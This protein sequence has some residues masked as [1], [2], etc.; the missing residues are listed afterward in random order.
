MS[1]PPADPDKTRHSQDDA[2]PVPWSARDARPVLNP[3]IAPSDDAATVLSRNLPMAARPEEGFAA[4][5]RGRRLGHYEL[6]EPIGVGGMAA[7]IRARDVHLDRLVALKILPPEMATD[8]E[9]VKRFEQEA[10]AAARLDHENIARVYDCGAEQGLSFIVFEFVEGENIRAILQRRGRIPVGE[11]VCYILQLAA[12]LAHAA[13]RG[14]VHRDIKPSNIIVGPEGRAKLVDMGLARNLGQSDLALTQP[15]VT[16][17]TF[18]YISPEQAL[19]PRQADCRS[20]I[21]SLGCTFYH[22]LT[23]Q[24]PVPEGTAARKLHHHQQVAPIDPRQLNP[25]VPDEIASI[26]ARMM[27]KNPDDRYQR[28]EELAQ[29]L[30]YLARKLGSP[31]LANRLLFVDTPPPRPARLRPILL[32]AAAAGILGVFV[33]WHAMTRPPGTFPTGRS[34]AYAGDSRGDN[35]DASGRDDQAPASLVRAS[36]EAASGR[37]LADLMSKKDP[38]V[39]VY[40]TQDLDLTRE[41]AE[42]GRVPGLIYAGHDADGRDRELTIQPKGRQPVT[43]RLKYNRDVAGEGVWSAFTIR[44]GRVTL[45]NL[46]FEVAA[47]RADDL[48]MA[49]LRLQENGLLTLEE[50]QFTQVNRT[51]ASG[52]SALDQGYVADVLVE[53]TRGSSVRPTLKL[54]GCYFAGGQ[55]AVA[56]A[57]SGEVNAWNCAFGP[58]AEL[59]HFGDRTGETDLQLFHCSALLSG[60]SA[61]YLEDSVAC[62]LAVSHCLFSQPEAPEAAGGAALIRQASL[63]ANVQYAGSKNRYHHLRAFWQN[64]GADGPVTDAANLDEF[65]RRAG[66]DNGSEELTASPWKESAPL[67]LLKKGEARPAFQLNAQEPALR[68]TIGGKE[69]LVGV[70]RCVWGTAYD[71]KLP[72]LPPTET[73]AG[74]IVD[75]TSD[76]AAAKNGP[77][78]VYQRLAGAVAD[79]HRGDTIYI[80]CNGPLPVQPLHLEDPDIDLTI[81][82]YKDYHPVLTLAMSSEP[83]A[84]LFRLNDGNL[85]LQELEFLLKPAKSG[86]LSQSV[87]S[88]AGTGHCSFQRCAMTLDATGSETSWPLAVTVLLDPSQVM[89]MDTSTPAAPDKVPKVD[90]D[91]CF[92]RGK[93]ELVAVRASRPLALKAAN[94]VIALA[95]SLLSV[96]G[97]STREPVDSG[98]NVKLDKVTAYLTDHLVLLR[99]SK[100]MKDMVRVDVQ[101]DNCLIASATR[102]GVVHFDGPGTNEQTVKD[103][104]SWA[105]QHNAYSN[106]QTMIDQPPMSDQKWSQSLEKEPRWLPK[107]QFSMPPADV[108]RSGPNDFKVPTSQA[109]LQSYGADVNDLPRP[110]T[111]SRG[112]AAQQSAPSPPVSPR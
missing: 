94:S 34:L 110:L 105:G 11:A 66:S 92:V 76:P 43:I 10:R 36:Y 102:K 109:D 60:G 33:L 85:K 75:P 71:P 40:L 99:T 22:M 44:G 17:G 73:V 78:R 16:L 107:A 6:I 95:G 80:R 112:A 88:V 8:A 42:S 21:Y 27:A 53:G 57:G 54:S 48:K 89:K 96:D 39:S 25:E 24:P 90:F 67:A 86:Y 20:D 35:G 23:G 70:Q 32:A 12:G 52:P 19:D 83:D 97:N 64:T 82:A 46:R 18:D 47:G 68:Q 9:I 98:I 77:A 38:V 62:R 4:T 15:G 59:F 87:V 103:R 51:A 14:V 31:E 41:Q 3:D 28:A 81:R 91:G 37:E 49:A 2:T 106:F 93:G 26:L 29:H 79:A 1:Q 13:S 45:R 56:V 111:D 84:A 50:C 55:D 30:L 72:P 7:V 101:Q 100:D 65:R 74:I 108:A 63:W 104:L 61:F 5:L 58:H 69:C